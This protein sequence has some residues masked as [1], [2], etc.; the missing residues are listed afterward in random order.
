MA[1]ECGFDCKPSIAHRVSSECGDC[2]K[3][4]ASV[5]ALSA[6][7]SR[8]KGHRMGWRD[9]VEK[10]IVY[11]ED[12]VRRDEGL[13]RT[14]RWFFELLR[15]VM[16]LGLLK[17]VADKSGSAILCWFW[18]LGLG[19]LGAS[20]YL[21]FDAVRFRPFAVLTE[22]R[23]GKIADQLFNVVAGFTVFFALVWIMTTAVDAISKAQTG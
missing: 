4:C 20:I 6:V 11:R 12:E 3:G 2:H 7:A 19:L 9:Y 23:F 1:R 14:V 21:L 18:A 13:R 8:L 15:N 22:G 5:S 10:A 16:L 17:Y